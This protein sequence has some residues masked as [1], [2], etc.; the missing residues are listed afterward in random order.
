MLK[1]V[2]RIFFL[3]MAI[4]CLSC[5][6]SIAPA[7]TPSDFSVLVFS[8][9]HF[10]PFY[11]TARFNTDPSA[12]TT[13]A[14]ESPSQWASFFQ[15]SA[16]T[17][18]GPWGTDTNYPLLTLALA[19]IKRNEGTTPLV[20][21]T[22]DLIGH[23]LPS[24][25]YQYCEGGNTTNVA[26]MQAFI[27]KTVAF[28]TSQVRVAAGNVPVL[29]AVG[30]IDS[31]TG[32]GP[33]STFL[34]HNA[35]TL[36]TQLLNGSVNHQ[37]F[38]STF[39]SGGYYSAQPLGSRLMVIGLN[40]NVMALGVPGDND[41]AVAAELAWLDSQ[42]GAA[43]ASGKKV[44][45]LMHVPPGANTVSTAPG[46]DGNGHIV[47]ATMMMYQSY[48]STFLQI[49]SKYPGLITLT[50]GAHTHMDEYRILTAN[51]VLIEVPG[52]SPCFGENPAYKI[53]TLTGDTLTPVDYTAWNYDLAVM[54]ADFGDNYTFS[55][56]YSISGPLNAGLLQLYSELAT[57]VPLT[58]TQPNAQQ[59]FYMQHY[60]SG[61][62]STHGNP[63][64]PWNPI[65]DANWP[66]FA[67]GIGKMS[68]T[69][70]TDCVNA[71]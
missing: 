68:Q 59:T 5:G 41:G 54:P 46:V 53:L 15:A 27:D 50:L 17:A 64:V 9:L 13:L 48:Q 33:D 49:L 39:T 31:Y 42:L 25:F 29:F 26:A 44:W 34:S 40:T 11:D 20:L 18:A 51:E 65:T 63:G 2:V 43:E 28:V 66:V 45:L 12:C 16:V 10:N 67:C 37:T 55:T 4:I 14:N 69:D 7:P 38:L 47:N 22:G 70:F 35:E 52:I 23:N 30:N 6:G 21:F 61:N 8:D 58:T 62:N 71:Y 60:L 32:Y 57:N 3:G 1:L 36:Y 56:A 24:L 19:S